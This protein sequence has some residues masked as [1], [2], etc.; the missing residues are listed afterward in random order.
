MQTRVSSLKTY[1]DAVA[2]VYSE[3]TCWTPDKVSNIPTTPY[4]F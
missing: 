3:E 4:T 2:R 1:W